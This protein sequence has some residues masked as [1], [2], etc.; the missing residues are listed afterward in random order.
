MGIEDILI[1]ACASWYAAYAISRTDGAFGMFRWLRRVAPL[2][3]LTTC[4][5]CLAPWCAA[6]LLVLYQSDARVVTLVL[7]A[8]GVALMLGTYTGATQQ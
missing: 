2:G 4:I 8:A 3:G 7:G 6:A 5:I 1:I